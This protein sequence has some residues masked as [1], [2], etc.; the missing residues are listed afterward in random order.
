MSRAL[1][2]RDVTKPSLKL[3]YLCLAN[4]AGEDGRNAFPSLATLS[5]NSCMSERA[6]RYSLR[7][8]ERLGVITRG[9]QSIASAYIKRVDRRPVVYD[10][11]LRAGGK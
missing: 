10:I 8:L 2:D 9:D 4:Y 1:E 3:I 5:K 11:V 7:Q 6:V